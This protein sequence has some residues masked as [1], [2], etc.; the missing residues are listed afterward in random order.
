VVKAKRSRAELA[1]AAAATLQPWGGGGGGGKKKGGGKAAPP[2]KPEL[3]Q[4]KSLLQQHCQRCSWAAPRFERLPHGGMR[5]EGGGYRYSVV[6][7]ASG[8][9]KVPKRKQQQQ[10]QQQQG[11]RSFSLRE[12]EDGWQRIEDAQNAAATRALFELAATDAQ[13]Q[14]AC[15]PLWAHLP[16]EFQEMWL[17]WQAEGEDG[18]AGEAAAAATE[19]AV[20]ARQEFVQQLLSR[21]GAQQAQQAAAAAVGTAAGTDGGGWQQDLLAAIAAAAGNEAQR[22]QQAAAQQ[23]VSERLHREQAQWR[24]SEEGRQWLADRGR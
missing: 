8:G 21:G 22:A 7:D 2:P 9:G 1:A 11:P 23:R 24:A 6:V 4:P 3:Q 19:E 12:A 20:A 17:V 5:L 13:L 14:E 18:E 10:Q 16:P 15:P